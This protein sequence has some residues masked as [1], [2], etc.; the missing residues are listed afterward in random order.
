MS[1]G[2]FEIRI[3]Q[4]KSQRQ[5]ILFSLGAHSSIYEIMIAISL[6]D[7][8]DSFFYRLLGLSE[9][10][11]K[12]SKILAPSS[13]IFPMGSNAMD[14]NPI[15]YSRYLSWGAWLSPLVVAWS[16]FFLCPL[17]IQN[18]ETTAKSIEIR[19]RKYQ[20]DCRHSVERMIRRSTDLLSDSSRRNPKDSIFNP[21][22]P[23]DKRCQLS[24]RI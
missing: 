8:R 9:I 6:E 19:R 22:L 16:S 23:P 4:I 10:L 11:Y 5:R 13:F 15:S 21:N 24:I 3:N 7:N 12:E 18:G 17:A 2:R 20:D 14:S 1:R